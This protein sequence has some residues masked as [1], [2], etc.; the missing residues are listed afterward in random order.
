MT[1]PARISVELYGIARR[2]AGTDRAAAAGRSLGEVLADLGRQFP[3]L[4][5]ACFDGGR[6]KPGFV[7]NLGGDRFVTDPHT[8]LGE[9]TSLLILSADAGG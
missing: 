5:E 2:R 9:A 1:T 3:A 4:A 8:P 7:A 6:L